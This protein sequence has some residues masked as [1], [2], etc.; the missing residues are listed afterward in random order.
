MNAPLN[1][2]FF[3]SLVVPLCLYLAAFNADTVLA[4]D[5]SW[6]R[7]FLTQNV[8]VMMPGQTTV[9]DTTKLEV[10]NSKYGGYFFQLKYLKDKYMVKN[11]DGLIQAYDGFLAGY[12]KTPGIDIYTSAVS[13]TSLNGT[14]GKW[15]LLKY[16]KDTVHQDI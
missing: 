16:A 4:Q 6:Q 2:S 12:F 8:V 7:V 3:K 15:I 14:M 13:D 10:I 1:S 9:V 11:G 5:S